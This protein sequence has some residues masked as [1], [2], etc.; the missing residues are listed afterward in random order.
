MERKIL[1]EEL[2]RMSYLLGYKRGVVIS[3]QNLVGVS[4]NPEKSGVDIRTNAPNWNGSSS[5][6]LSFTNFSTDNRGIIVNSSN[7]GYKENLYVL[8]VSLGIGKNLPYTIKKTDTLTIPPILTRFEFID[9]SFPYSDNMITPE[10]NKNAKAESLIYLIRDT[11][12][13]N[14]NEGGIDS[15]KNIK[16]KGFAD[17][18]R[19]TLDVPR[20][21]K[22]LD[23]SKVGCDKPYCGERDDSKRNL[24]LAEQ[25]AKRMATFLKNLV[26]QKINVDIPDDKFIFDKP[27]SAFNPN[28][29]TDKNNRIGKKS[30]YVEIIPSE[31]KSGS[32]VSSEETKVITV[33]PKPKQGV[34]NYKGYELNVLENIK[35]NTGYSVIT[36]EDNDIVRKLIS[37]GDI[38]DLSVTGKINGKTSAKGEITGNEVKI[39]GL[40]WGNLTDYEEGSYANMRYITDPGVLCAKRFIDGSIELGVYKV[41]LSES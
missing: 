17:S 23:H 18:A 34:I 10:I 19:P 35:S 30:V 16:L 28:I 40:S 4:N 25:R 1:S 33:V 9:D 32:D 15:I 31:P 38:P 14:I 7:V 27:E 3:E 26:K 37:D 29:K 39:D 22:G 11:I 20:G 12:I 21:Y 5:G 13:K 24:F 8:S 2:G 6:D 41:V 36:V